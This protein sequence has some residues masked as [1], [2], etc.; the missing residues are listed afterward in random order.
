MVHLVI[1]IGVA[2]DVAIGI[3]G[4]A[5]ALGGTRQVEHGVLRGMRDNGR[6]INNLTLSIGIEMAHRP[7]LPTQHIAQIAGT[8]TCQRHAPADTAVEPRLTVPVA[9]GCQGQSA[10]QGVEI[11]IGGVELDATGQL[12]IMGCRR[13]ELAGALGRRQL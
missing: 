7:I 9:I 10:T 3:H 6:H 13:L 5:P 8:P 1:T 4:R 2:T 11:R 12:T